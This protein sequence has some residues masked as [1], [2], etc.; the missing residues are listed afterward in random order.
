MRSLSFPARQQRG[1]T[2]IELMI[3]VAIVGVLAAIAFASYESHVIKARRSA[4][5][6]C[7]QQGVQLIE[8]YYT[9]NMSYANVPLPT[10]SSDAVQFYDLSFSVTP[11]ANAFKLTA[12]P[13][14][15]SPQ[16]KDTQCG[17]LSI[18]QKGA[19]TTSTGAGE[20]TCW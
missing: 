8:R 9:T 14:T 2:L 16:A 6:V 18:D 5:S 13:R 17:A 1:F 11:T 10:C 12:T 3:V 15:G 20:G 19:R 4:A 7:L